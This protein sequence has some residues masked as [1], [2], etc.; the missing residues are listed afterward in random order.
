MSAAEDSRENVSESSAPA[1]SPA[2]PRSIRQIRKVESSE[3]KGNAL[4]AGSAA[5]K[6][7]GSA[8]GKSA[9]SSAARI[10]LGRRRIDIV[11]IESD[12]GV[13][14]A[15]LGIAEDIVRLGERLKLLLGGLIPRIHVRMVFPRQLAK[16]LA[17]LLRRRGLLHAQNLVI[18]FF[19]SRS[20]QSKSDPG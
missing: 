12:L 7:P 3:I 20:H 10:G 1:G 2:S 8:S 15:L 9:C 6:S 14:F 18:I 17:N 16:R 4:S 19:G 11:R 13:D 5:R